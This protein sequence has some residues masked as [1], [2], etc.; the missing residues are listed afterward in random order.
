MFGNQI[1]VSGLGE[2]VVA[3]RPSSKANGLSDSVE[4]LDNEQ[5]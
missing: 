5:R 4:P 3:H 2:K 1:D